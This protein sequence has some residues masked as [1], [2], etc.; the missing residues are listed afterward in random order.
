MEEEARDP[1]LTVY[2]SRERWIIENYRR[3]IVSKHSI[4]TTIQPKQ[5]LKHHFSP[6]R[7]FLDEETSNTQGSQNTPAFN[8][9]SE[10]ACSGLEHF[11][12]TQSDSSKPVTETNALNTS[13]SVAAMS[14][15]SP[16]S[17]VGLVAD[18][19]L[20]DSEE[21]ISPPIKK[22]R[23]DFLDDSYDSIVNEQNEDDPKPGQEQN[24]L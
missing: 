8:R 6:V 19:S 23:V 2:K 11:D 17:S 14:A 3:H 15:V 1:T 10:E 4:K 18:Y 5:T 20:S 9:G 7:C 13:Q 22:K 16:V 21:E 12:A 24:F